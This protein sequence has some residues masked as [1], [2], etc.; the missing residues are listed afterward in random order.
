[1]LPLAEEKKQRQWLNADCDS[2]ASTC[3]LHNSLIPFLEPSKIDGSSYELVIIFYVV[4]GDN[5]FCRRRF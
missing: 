3:F 1:M 5:Y 2:S 4:S